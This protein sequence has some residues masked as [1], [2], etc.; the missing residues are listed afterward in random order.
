MLAQF[1]KE[2]QRR[3]ST[4]N[5]GRLRFLVTSRPYDDIRENFERTLRDL[6]TIRLRGEEENDQIRSEID[7]VIGIRV[8]ELSLTLELSALVQDQLQAKLLCMQHRTY[9]WL[10][11]ALDN[12]KEALKN[13]RRPQ[14]ESVEQL[15]SSVEDAYEKIL[16]RIS[17]KER[18]NA[19]ASS[20]IR[21]T[22][23]WPY[24]LA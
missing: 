10:Y 14:L 5:T 18:A 19:L 4:T 11:L 20:S 13:S 12:I 1:H 6:L 16:R 8:T 24:L 22:C 9:L 3:P 15:P 2:A 7:L 17:G 21:I 23:S